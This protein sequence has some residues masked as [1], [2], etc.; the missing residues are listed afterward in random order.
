MDIY[1]APAGGSNEGQNFVCWSCN[2]G[3]NYKFFLSNAREQ[4]PQTTAFNQ[5]L[6]QRKT[7]QDKYF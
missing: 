2:L 7:K 3:R 4:P 1:S 6:R 5:Q